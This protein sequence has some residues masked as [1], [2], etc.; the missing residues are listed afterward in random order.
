[1]DDRPP[2]TSYSKRVDVSPKNLHIVMM[3]TM[4]TT[5][6]LLF[7]FLTALSIAATVHADTPAENLLKNPDSW[8]RSDDGLKAVENILSWQTEH[9]DWPKNVNTTIRKPLGENKTFAGTFDNG[10]TCGELRLLGRA[11]RLT[12]NELYG[13][14]FLLGFDHILKAQYAN[15][16]W[17]QYYPLSKDYHRHITF[18]DDTMIAVMQFLSD[19]E[20]KEDFAFL[21]QSRRDAAKAAVE[22]GIRCIVKCQVVVEGVPT[23]WCAQHDAETLAPTQARS[24]EHPSLSGAESSGI[25]RFLMSIEQPPQEVIDAVKGGAAWFESVKIDGYRYQKSKTGPALVKDPSAASLWAR[26]YDIKTNRPVFSDR[27]G[28][29]K[30]DIDEIGSERRGGYTWYGNWGTNVLKLYAKWPH[31]G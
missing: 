4:K 10:A 19:T 14:A 26:F 20:R 2:T 3:T 27:D 11:F 28:V 7:G 18:N 5:A 25:L 8:F 29:V 22:R 21:D 9:G 30:Y 17:P 12:G 23:V 15:G 1:L 13:K 31:R 16:G 24:Y 6:R